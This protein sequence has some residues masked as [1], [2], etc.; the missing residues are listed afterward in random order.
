MIVSQNIFE[1]IKIHMKSKT[2][3]LNAHQK[4]RSNIQFCDID[5]ISYNRKYLKQWFKFF[6]T[7]SDNYEEL[8]IHFGHINVSSNDYGTETDI[9]KGFKNSKAVNWYSF[10]RTINN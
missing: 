7:N 8:R 2:I 10:E 9:K 5:I 3:T 6:F 4:M 1:N